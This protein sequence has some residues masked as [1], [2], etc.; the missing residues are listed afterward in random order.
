LR[1]FENESSDKNYSMTN[2]TKLGGRSPSVVLEHLLA[3]LKTVVSS[4]QASLEPATKTDLHE[5]E[6]RLTHEIKSLASLSPA[7]QGALEKLLVRSKS[8]ANR[9]A[10]LDAQTQPKE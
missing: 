4:L 1:H 2:E 10:A 8:I 7:D 5:M 9:L 3:E 6:V